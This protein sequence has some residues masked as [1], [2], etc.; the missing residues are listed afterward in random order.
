MVWFGIC[1]PEQFLAPSEKFTS[2]ASNRCLE[3]LPGNRNSPFQP[4]LLNANNL[5]V[6]IQF[7]VM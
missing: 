5:R 3:F 6:G 1:P 4:S 7:A 2:L